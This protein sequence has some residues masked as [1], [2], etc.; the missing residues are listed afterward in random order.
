MKFHTKFRP[1][2]LVRDK[3]TNDQ[4]VI[5][6]AEAVW[7]SRRD[8]GQDYDTISHHRCNERKRPGET[9]QEGKYGIFQRLSMAR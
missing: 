8:E 5:I 9:Y 7:Y 2:D 6:E 1:G 3:K 4:G